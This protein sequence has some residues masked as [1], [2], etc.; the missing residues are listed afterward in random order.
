[1]KLPSITPLILTYN[2]EINIRRTLDRLQWADRIVVVDSYSTDETLDIARS[3]SNVDIVRREFDTFANQCNFGLEHVESEWVLSL[4]ADYVCSEDLIEEISTLSVS[5]SVVGYS[6]NFVYCVF[7]NPLRGTLYPSRTVLYRRSKATYRQEGHGHH[8]QID[9]TVRQLE[10]PMYH[11]DR[12]SLDVWLTNQRRYAQDEAKDLL[13]NP[14]STLT[15]RIRRTCI[16]A[17]LLT[18][19]YCLFGKGLILDGWNGW[20]YTLQRTYAELLLALEMLD[21]HLRPS[22]RE[23]FGDREEE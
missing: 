21:R 22:G 10:A 23:A 8:V 11:D 6:V 19:L 17:P 14:S 20:Y 9:G 4:D 18:P 2:E 7:G 3:Y 15:D 13:S 16:L 12:K 5:P 1:M